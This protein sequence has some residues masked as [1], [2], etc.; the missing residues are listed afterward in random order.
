[1]ITD[2][3]GRQTI[4]LTANLKLHQ[5]TFPDVTRAAPNRVQTHHCLPGLSTVSSVQPPIAAISS[6]VAL[7]RPSASRF[8][9]TQIAASHIVDFQRDSC[10]A[11]IRDDQQG[12]AAWSE[13]VQRSARLLCI[14]LP[15]FCNR[16]R[17]SPETP[18]QNRF[19]QTHRALLLRQQSRP[20]LNLHSDPP[21]PAAR[22]ASAS[23]L[24]VDVAAASASPAPLDEALPSSASLASS[25]DLRAPIRGSALAR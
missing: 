16:D 12:T 17:G 19:L 9:I 24:C 22:S 3:S 15:E 11:A 1:M 18:G 10:A 6:L 23:A 4:A 25:C 13:T 14:P 5:Q 21:T 8:P 2:Q 7:S 20:Q